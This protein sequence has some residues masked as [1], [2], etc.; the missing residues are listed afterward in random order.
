MEYSLQEVQN[1]CLANNEVYFNKK[2]L[3]ESI[4]GRPVDQITL[5]SQNAILENKPVVYLSNRV[6]CGETPGQYMLQGILE[7]LTDFEDA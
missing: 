6:H 5:S 1:K 7:K 4:E 2:Q 3:C